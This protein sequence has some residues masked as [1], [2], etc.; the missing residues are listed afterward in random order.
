MTLS[1][2]LL[3]GCGLAAALT[4]S[5]EATAAEDAPGDVAVAE[6]A[7]A[8]AVV[9]EDAAVPD[10]AVAEDAS[11]DAA[12]ERA[13]LLFARGKESMGRGNWAKAAALFR[14]AARIKDTPGLRYHVAFCEENAGRLLGA[15]AEYEAAGQLLAIRPAPDVEALLGPALAR[16]EEK[17]PE[18]RLEFVGSVAPTVVSIDGRGLATWREPVRL[19]PGPHWVHVEAPGRRPVTLEFTLGAG[20]RH[21]LRVRLEAEP[22]AKAPERVDS[23][24]AQWHTPVLVTGAAMSLAGAGLAVWGLVDRSAALEEAAW[25]RSG[26]SRL[27]GADGSC[28]GASDGLALA[29]RDL[30]AAERRETRAMQL[31]IGGLAGVGVGAAMTVTSLLLWPEG[32]VE[33]G[34]VV[35]GDMTGVRVRGRF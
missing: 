10:A 6:D 16:L 21:A 18:V 8:E 19:D 11:A 23:P 25:A 31:A 12:V 13:R 17:I 33:V 28:E 20:Q 3:A 32:A 30:A 26:I 1:S 14:E 9:T 29:C 24:R 2:A 35:G 7:S 27:S 15:R 22:T 34:G 4:V 5:V